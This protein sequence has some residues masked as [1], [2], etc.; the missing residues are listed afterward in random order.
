[1][2]IPR[3]NWTL[4][5]PLLALAGCADLSTTADRV[6]TRI[7]VDFDSITIQLGADIPAGV[8]VFDQHDEPM[9]RLP[10]WAE[11]EWSSGNGSVVRVNGTELSSVASGRARVVAR[12]ADLETEAIIR[13][14]PRELR[15]RV[16]TVVV[17]QAEGSFSGPSV[18]VA[19]RDAD[20]AIALTGDKPNFFRPIVRVTVLHDGE[21]AAVID[22]ERE[23]ESVP[24]Q[25]SVSNRQATWNAVIPGSLVREGTSFV[26]EADPD[27]AI[28]RAEGSQDRYPA[29]GSQLLAFEISVRVA[30]AYLTQSIQRLDGSVPLVAGRDALLRVFVESE[31]E[32]AARP[33]VAVTLLRDGAILESYR[34]QRAR[35]SIPLETDEGDLAD[36]WNTLLPG[37]LIAPGLE[38]VIEVDP[39]RLLPHSADSRTRL[40][41]TGTRSLDVRPVPTL[42]ARVIPVHQTMRGTTGRVGPDNLDTFV[43]PTRAVF[44]VAAVDVDLRTAYS[45]D[46]DLT[47]EDGWIDLLHE[48]EALREVDGSARYYYGVHTNPPDAVWGGLGFVGWPAAIGY[49]RMPGAS[50]VMA[51]EL[52]HNFGL[53]HAPCGGAGNPDP[54][55][56]YSLGSTGVFG[57]DLFSRTVRDPARSK[58][59]MTYCGPEWISDYNYTKVLDFRES[60]D[61]TM[62]GP[63]RAGAPEPALLIWGGSGSDGLVLEPAFELDMR[64]SMPARGGAY[65][66]EGIGRDGTRVFAI[67]FEPSR[68]DHIDGASSFAFALP[69]GIARPDELVELRLTG[70]EGTVSRRAGVRPL[71]PSFSIEPS[72][73]GQVTVGWRTDTHPM[74][75]I[76]DADTGEVLSFARSGRSTLPTAGRRLEILASDGV[77]TVRSNIR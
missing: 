24:L 4:L 52:G 40:P 14:N 21:P 47:T 30:A 57:Y 25:A 74:L 61:W 18:L 51:H 13:V 48:I 12:I 28:T 63:D 22:I 72:T 64:R 68:I 23:R 5:L 55:F 70:P 56:P 3:S 2:I 20:I 36:S 29:S 27:G 43:R 31:H 66:V 69:A 41:A 42:W 49:D 73:G 37:T 8:T 53:F 44:P 6:P 16:D 67:S 34:L 59:L 46:A 38:M 32:I 11:P 1:M 7:A 19:G 77:R 62:T 33:E 54:D 17:T 60:Y 71:S 10:F 50:Q 76:R 39:D 65:R 26:V 45:T 9:T 75:L 58:D 35:I 15:L